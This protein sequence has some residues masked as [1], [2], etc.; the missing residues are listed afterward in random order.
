MDEKK[1]NVKTMEILSIEE[2]AALVEGLKRIKGFSFLV[3]GQ[4]KIMGGE[5]SKSTKNC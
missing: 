3:D 2:I 4:F 5:T 1:I